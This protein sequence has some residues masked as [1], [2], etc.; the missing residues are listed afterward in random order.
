[1]KVLHVVGTRPNFTKI[2]PIMD[3]MKGHGQIQQILVH[4]G[5]HYDDALSQVF[6]DQLGIPKP[7][8]NIGVGSS[9]HGKQTGQMMIEL[10]PLFLEQQ[11][12]WVL[13]VGDVNSTLAAT[14]T[15]SKLGI[16]VAHVEAGLRSFD[17]SMPEEINRLATDVLAD[18]LF[19]TEKSGNINLRNE[20]IP[21]E[22]IIFVGNVMIDTLLKCRQRAL[23]SDILSRLQL[24]P[25]AY[26]LVTLHR[27]SSV[28]DPSRLQ[29]LIKTLNEIAKDIP[30]IFPCHPRTMNRLHIAGLDQEVT[31]HGATSS[32]GEK[33]RIVLLDPLGY[34]DF[35]ALMAQAKCVFT[36]SGGIQEE[37]T[38]L[39]VPCLTMRENTER[40]VTVE[41]GTNILV[42]YSED[43]IVREVQKIMAGKGKTGRIPDL[44]DG[45]AATRIV[46][47]MC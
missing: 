24:T 32:Q 41:E 20:G 26:A 34:L 37:T 27:P 11:P 33:D 9:S 42:G 22:K 25:G 2:A 23:T 45:K 47:A 12:D 7:D 17:R 13:V 16:R 31:V 46:E 10:E 35:L 8:I 44:W 30:V 19:T 43:R 5:Q 15:A 40:P 36:D 18:L 1:M 21:D 28:D 3:A 4:T 39:G 6:F 29:R 14:I 38:I